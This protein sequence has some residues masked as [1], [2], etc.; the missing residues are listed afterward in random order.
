MRR[1]LVA[2]RDIF[3]GE[4]LAEDM[5]ILKRPAV[6]LSPSW[7]EKVLGRK[8]AHDIPAETPLTLGLI[9]W[10]EGASG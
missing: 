8:A 3:R 7:L 10:R 2:S 5:L 1:S 6:G 4:I 9:D